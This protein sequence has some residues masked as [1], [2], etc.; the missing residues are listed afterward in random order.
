MIKPAYKVTA[1]Q[2]FRFSQ[3]Y[4]LE[5]YIFEPARATIDP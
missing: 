3:K 4:N 2:V 5:Q 1:M